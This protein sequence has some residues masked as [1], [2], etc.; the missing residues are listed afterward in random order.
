MTADID[1]PEPGKSPERLFFID[2][3]RVAMVI[4]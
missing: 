3:L 1:R 4:L 2:N